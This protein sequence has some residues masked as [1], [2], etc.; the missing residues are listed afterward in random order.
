MVK[1]HLMKSLD[2]SGYQ[3]VCFFLLQLMY[4][5]PYPSSTN[6]IDEMWQLFHPCA[7]YLYDAPGSVYVP[8]Y[9]L[10]VL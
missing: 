7:C 8:V 4:S 6:L 9:V 3:S 2:Q 5:C 10:P 1:S